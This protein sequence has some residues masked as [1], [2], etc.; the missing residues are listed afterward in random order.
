MI[1]HQLPFISLIIPLWLVV[2]MAGW[3]GAKAIWPALVVTGGSYA[4]TMFLSASYLGPAIPD[5]LSSIVSLICLT[6]LL[7]F[8]QPAEIW[9]FPNERASAQTVHR[10]PVMNWKLLLKAWTPFVLL[11]IFIVNWATGGVQQWLTQTS[12]AIP[13]GA[14]AHAITAADHTVKVTYT[15]SWLAATGTGIILAALV[16]AVLLQIPRRTVTKVARETIA[17]LMKPLITIATIVGFAYVA[18]YSGMSATLSH[19]LAATGHWFPFLAPFLGWLGVFLTG[20]DTSSN[21]LFSGVQSHTA[22]TLGLNPVLTVSANTSGGVA[23]KMISPQSIAV[24]TAATKLTN[25]EG[26]L[27]RCTVLHSLGIVTIVGII[28]YLQAYFLKGMVP[29]LK[30]LPTV[31]AAHG[32]S[33]STLVL[34]SISLVAIVVV[35]YLARSQPKLEPA[36]T[37]IAPVTE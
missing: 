33:S 35:T 19:T 21:A 7:R 17:E 22:Q 4:I 9:R 3:R 23:A 11:I 18:N 26:N 34:L 2:I 29:A 31:A 8:W 10:G 25:Q 16:S 27:F 36:K 1:G 37:D 6:T 32:L 15:F 13:F 14:L 28:T 24:A 20:S 5:I 12:I 30:E